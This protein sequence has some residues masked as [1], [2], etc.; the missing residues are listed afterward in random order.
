LL[1]QAH[2]SVAPEPGKAGILSLQ[3]KT[4]KLTLA[5]SGSVGFAVAAASGAD[6]AR[7]PL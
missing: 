2:A 5:C 7:I 4:K 3:L 1:R 6:C